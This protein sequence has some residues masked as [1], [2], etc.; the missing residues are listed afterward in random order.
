MTT[1][2]LEHASFC[3]PRPGYD[4]PRIESYRATRYAD[5]GNPA[6]NTLVVRCQEC[7]NATYDG[8]QKTRN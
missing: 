4:A 5:D 6:G 1:S 3:R 7:G 2:T 8:V